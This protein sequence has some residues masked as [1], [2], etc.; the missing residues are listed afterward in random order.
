M[1]LENKTAIITGA[2]GTIGLATARVYLREGA[3]LVLAD[4]DGDALARATRDF[5]EDRALKLGAD[6][7]SV[8]ETE[9][10][11][12]A[13]KD[14][15]GGID[16]FFANAGIEGRTTAATDYPLDLHDTI[17]ETNVKGILVGVQAVLPGMRDGGSIIMTSS[18]AGLMGSPMNISYSASKHAVIGLRRS[19]AV[20]AGQRSIRVNS[21]HPGFVES[22]MLSR[23]M[24][25][26]G[27]PA[28]IR[29]RFTQ[30]IKLGKFT[31]AVDVA[32]AALFL[33]SDESRGITD[34]ALVVDGGVV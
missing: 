1:R 13:A 15:F 34:Q 29:R 30:R 24:D 27:D 22:P 7:T 21:L 17:M 18:I 11:V 6:V 3:N 32:N 26:Y 16:I 23:L 5:P 14:A 19:L 12:R 4:R 8:G 25:G 31:D 20:P 2:A 9:Q 10:M 33:A 28:E